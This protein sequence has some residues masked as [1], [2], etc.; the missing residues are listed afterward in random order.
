MI[1][2]D[3][4][5]PSVQ[6]PHIWF[7]VIHSLLSKYQSPHNKNEQEKIYNYEINNCLTANFYDYGWCICSFTYLYFLQ[8]FFESL[9]SM[10]N[11]K[12]NWY[13]YH[14]LMSWVHTRSENNLEYLLI[15][16]NT[17]HLKMI[18][19]KIQNYSEFRQKQSLV[20]TQTFFYFNL[21]PRADQIQTEGKHVAKIVF[22][23]KQT[24]KKFTHIAHSLHVS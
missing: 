20:Q 9:S 1:F 21:I 4:R 23:H 13:T 24:Y 17:I 15:P 14:R 12:K 7:T 5:P 2:F 18:A 6:S 16:L 8:N 11:K 22:Q 10:Y 19:S 3:S